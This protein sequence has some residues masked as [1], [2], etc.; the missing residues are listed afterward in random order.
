MRGIALVARYK[1]PLDHKLVSAVRGG[2]QEHA[3][4]QSGPERVR[5]EE[6]EREIED[7]Q[8]ARAGSDC[9]NRRPAA[10]HEMQQRDKANDRAANVDGEL[11]HVRPDDGCHPAFKC[12]NKSQGHYNGDGSNTACPER[13]ADHD[14]NGPNAH[15]FSCCSGDEKN[16]GGD[17]VQLLSKTAI[18]ELIG[19]EH[20]TAKILRNKNQADDD[21]AKQVA[22]D[23]LKKAEVAAISNTGRADDG[24]RTGFSANNGESNG[25]PGN[26]AVGQKIITQRPLRFAK[27]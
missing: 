14:G 16:S 13:D 24:E 2:V 26:V 20:L 7:L 21:A 1:Q 19:G 27:P 4:N 22:E 18:N 15:A 3:A 12:I 17:T 8:L 9:V 11:D 23:K 25:P 5:L 10:R 6:V